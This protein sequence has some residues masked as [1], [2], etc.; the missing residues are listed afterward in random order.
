MTPRTQRR[1]LPRRR[2]HHPQAPDRLPVR[3]GQAVGD[4]GIPLEG[5]RGNVAEEREVLAAEPTAD[6]IGEAGLIKLV[7]TADET[8]H[9]AH[10]QPQLWRIWPP[11][12][13]RAQRRGEE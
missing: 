13:C 5:T 3:R 7:E 6:Q 4:P 9:V 8:S 2:E 1:Q 12:G 11:L 10:P